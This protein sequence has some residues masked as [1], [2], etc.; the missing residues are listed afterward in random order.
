MLSKFK[1]LDVKISIN[2]QYL[3]RNI[4]R[5]PANL[6]HLTEAHIR[7]HQCINVTEER[8]QG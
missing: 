3:F 5:F 6:G 1:D 7:F 8:Y 2:V 4:D